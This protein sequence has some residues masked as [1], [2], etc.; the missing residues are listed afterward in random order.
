M[1][2]RLHGQTDRQTDRQMLTHTETNTGTG[3]ARWFEISCVVGCAQKVVFLFP[4]ETSRV[5]SWTSGN[6]GILRFAE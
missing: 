1:R 4:L 3:N 6:T 5:F 2:P